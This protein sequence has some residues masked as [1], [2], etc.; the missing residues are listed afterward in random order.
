[1]PEHEI[2]FDYDLTLE[3][4][5]RVYKTESPAVALYFERKYGAKFIVNGDVIWLFFV[6]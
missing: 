1:M 6:D 4:S 5:M 2:T 3:M